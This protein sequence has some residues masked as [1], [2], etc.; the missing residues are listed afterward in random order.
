MLCDVGAVEELH[1]FSE[2]SSEVFEVTFEEERRRRL[3]ERGQRQQRSQANH[4]SKLQLSFNESV[5]TN[6][7]KS[8]SE[9]IYKD[10]QPIRDP[11]HNKPILHLY[12][13]FS[14]TFELVP[15]KLIKYMLY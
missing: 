11:G 15:I 7:E 2:V 14:T 9:F 5:P 3:K 1:C 6:A 8:A 13:P 10:I 4:F 12:E